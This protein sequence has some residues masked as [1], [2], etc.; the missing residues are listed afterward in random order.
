MKVGSLRL[1]EQNRTELVAQTGIGQQEVRVTPL[2]IANMMATIAR[3][4]KAFQVSAVSSVQYQNGTNMFS[5][6]KQED[7]GETNHPFHSD[8]TSAVFARCGEFSSRG[9]P[10]ICR[11]R[12]YESPGRRARPRQGATVERH[13]ANELYTKWFAGYFPFRDPEYALVAV[14][15]D[16][17]VDEGGIYPIFKDS[18]DALYRLDQGMSRMKWIMFRF[19]LFPLSC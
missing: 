7:E 2:G 9:R 19:L 5:F 12:L 11:K 14:N 4:G 15:M 18:V 8:E 10:L 13:K 17:L 1:T 16:V 3:G 6:P